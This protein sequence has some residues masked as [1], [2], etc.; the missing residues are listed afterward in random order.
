MRWKANGNIGR[1]F[2]SCPVHTWSLNMHMRVMSYNPRPMHLAFLFMCVLVGTLPNLATCGR[3]GVQ[4]SHA[5][6]QL[7]PGVWAESPWCCGDHSS[8][9]NE[10]KSFWTSLVL[11]SSI[12]FCPLC[13]R[14]VFWFLCLDMQIMITQTGQLP[15]SLAEPGSQ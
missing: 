3:A 11:L 7:P 4:H 15:T 10:A 5:C 2:L 13:K 9:Q 14:L 8:L 1:A 6:P 12:I